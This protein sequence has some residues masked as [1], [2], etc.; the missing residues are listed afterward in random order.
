MVVRTSRRC[1]AQ[2]EGGWWCRS[3]EAPGYPYGENCMFIANDWHAS[4]VPAYL[5][6]KYRRAG[7]YRDA[8]CALIIHNLSHQGV[9][10]A[11]TFAYL[12]LPDDW[13]APLLPAS[14]SC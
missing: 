10:P 1:K 14:A 12:G 8:R 9:E 11:A 2:E 4:L 6:G 7:V 3:G 13:C 5:A